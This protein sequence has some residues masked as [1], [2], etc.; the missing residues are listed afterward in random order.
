MAGETSTKAA[1]P[2]LAPPSRSRHKTRA[3]IEIRM[4]DGR[5]AAL[6]A[7]RSRCDMGTGRF[8]GTLRC[9][10]AAPGD[11]DL[12]RAQATALQCAA[13]HLPYGGAGGGLAMPAAGL[14]PADRRRALTA[15]GRAF[16]DMV[17]AANMLTGWLDGSGRSLCPGMTMPRQRIAGLL[18]EDAIALTAAAAVASRH[19][20]PGVWVL[21]GFDQPALQLARRLHEAGWRLGAAFDGR[22]AIANPRG[23]CPT[24]LSCAMAEFGSLAVLI[25]ERGTRRADTVHQGNPELVVVAGQACLGVEAGGALPRTPTLLEL[26]PGAVAPEA[27][28]LLLARGTAVIPE[29]IA[30]AGAPIFAHLSRLRLRHRL[31][32]SR[33]EVLSRL[34]TRFAERLA[35]LDDGHD[36][37]LR[38]AATRAAGHFAGALDGCSVLPL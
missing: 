30:G 16:P 35:A 14:S 27:E 32:W 23:L 3:L 37:N 26:A 33:G 15:Y 24:E 9:T 29:L 25:G 10:A 31:D 6:E 38:Q 4:T 2:G 17:P 5:L 28:A 20:R 22:V 13:F 36:P 11:L 19:P 1:D 21:Q 34:R 8:I 12:S 18:R 7:W